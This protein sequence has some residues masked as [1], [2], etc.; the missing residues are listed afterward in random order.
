MNN[1]LTRKALHVADA[2]VKAWP[3]PA[4]GWKYKSSYAACNDAAPADA[5][6]MIHFYRVLAPALAG[7]IVIYNGDTD[8]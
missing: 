6:S 8:P 2:P 5:K 1:P 4:E 3:G 7:L